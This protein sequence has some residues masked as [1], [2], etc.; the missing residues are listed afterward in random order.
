MSRINTSKA[1]K[2]GA[3]LASDKAAAVSAATLA[4][5]GAAALGSKSV[6]GALHGNPKAAAMFFTLTG[7]PALIKAGLSAASSLGV[8]DVG[9]KAGEALD[10]LSNM[11]RSHGLKGLT[12]LAVAAVAYLS[13]HHDIKR[14]TNQTMALSEQLGRRFPNMSRQNLMYVAAFIV[15]GAV[16]LSLY[17]RGKISIPEQEKAESKL[18]EHNPNPELQFEQFF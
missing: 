18:G 11:R 2:L 7:L 5:L 8:K 10:F 14:V 6:R 4:A 16:M 3:A 13:R 9:G 12:A 1:Q 15:L 17:K